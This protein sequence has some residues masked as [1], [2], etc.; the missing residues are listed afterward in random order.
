M[1]RSAG[2]VW[3][4]GSRAERTPASQDTSM[5]WTP[6]FASTPRNHASGSADNWS[7]PFAQPVPG[8]QAEMDDANSV[9]DG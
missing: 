6:Y 8:S 3:C 4:L 2:S 1:I 7:A 5:T 9:L